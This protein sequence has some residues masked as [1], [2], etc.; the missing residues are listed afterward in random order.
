MDT[1][2]SSA[3]FFQQGLSGIQGAQT[4]M[5]RTM[6]EISSGK[7]ELSPAM[8][9]VVSTT[10]TK[11]E[12]SVS[13]L[14]Q[15]QRNAEAA[16]ARLGQT[17]NALQG[18]TEV[19]SR[20][21]ELAIEFNKSTQDDAVSRAVLRHEFGLL[22]DQMR[23][24]LNTQDE[25]GGYIFAGSKVTTKPYPPGH[26]QIYAGDGLALKVQVAEGR[27]LQVGQVFS[28]PVN[29]DEIKNFLD[30]LDALA[31]GSE[32]V[33]NEADLAPMLAALDKVVLV[34]AQVGQAMNAVAMARADNEGELYGYTT[35]LSALRDTDYASAITQ[36]NQQTLLLQATQSTLAKVQG[37]SLFNVI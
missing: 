7:R 37:L 16:D 32:P 8:D 3:L 18:M 20:A 12:Q 17:E 35:S 30:T 24:L 13:R 6:Q 28:D 11:L 25:R 21:R 10:V 26:P 4:G 15:H 33:P 5:A 34:R 2:I 29:P 19:I 31:T 14:T 9:P 23:E 36:L 27:I 22:R 1:R